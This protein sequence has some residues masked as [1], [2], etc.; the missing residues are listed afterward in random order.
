MKALALKYRPETFDDVVE[1]KAI[2]QIL[3]EQVATKT[4]K[5]AY[6]FTG[7]AGTGKTTC[8]RILANEINAG[9]GK[10]IEIDAASN[11]GVD[12]VREI[13][14]DAKFK[15]LDAEYKVYILDECHMF[16]TGA[17]NAMLKLIEEPPAKTIFIFCTTDPQKIPATILS[18]VQRYDFQRITYHG[19]LNRLIYIMEDG[20]GRQYE[21]AALEYIAKLAEGGMRD[22]ITMLDK[23]LSFSKD[24]LTLK[25]VVEALGTVDYD[26]MFEIL[27]FLLARKTAPLLAKLDTIHKSGADLKQFMKQFGW[28]VLD[29]CKYQKLGNF[30][31][32]QIPE[33][34]ERQMERLMGF[35]E[36]NLLEI[37]H[38]VLEVNNL[39]KWEANAK[40]LIEAS[41]IL[42]CEGV[43]G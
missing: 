10:P 11:N 14:N 38:K 25:D 40:A 36:S 21:R 4:H 32:L 6:L 7:G 37:L 33:I 31:Y 13:I 41:F 30:E 16:S 5:H 15:A 3:Q 24:V 19:I 29:V 27:E 18:R 22:A 1:Q 26:T 34:Y 20:E 42:H 9:K 35:Q 12:D 43:G 2:R 17:W 39:I 23:C 8:A 28:F